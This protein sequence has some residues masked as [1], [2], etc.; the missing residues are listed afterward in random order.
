MKLSHG[1]LFNTKWTLSLL[2]FFV[3]AGGIFL[4][5]TDLSAPLLDFHPTRQLFGAIKARGIYY[6]TLPDVPAWQKDLAV[7]LYVVEA[8][9]E[10]PLME[11]LTAWLYT[12]SGVQ[13]AIPRAI[14]A[15]FWM[16]GGIFLFLLSRD[17]S[18][19]ALAATAALA[20]YLLVPYS[21]SASRAFQPDPLMV[22]FI[23][24]F[25]W[26]LENWARKLSW[27]WAVLSGLAGG[28]A[29]FIKF[30]ALLFIVVPAFGAILAWPGL[31]NALRNRQTWVIALL[32]ALLPGAYLV[33]GTLLNG[34]LNQ[35]FAGRMYPDLWLSLYFYLRWFLKLNNVVNILWLTLAFLGWLVFS[36]GSLR[37]FLGSLWV[38]YFIFGMTVTHH[39]SSHDYYSLPV[40]P[41]VAVCLAQLAAQVVPAV[42]NYQWPAQA[43]ER[44][45]FPRSLQV[46]TLVLLLASVLLLTFD[47]YSSQRAD[48]Y[49]PQAAFWA[50]VGDALNHQS[51]VL[52]L[53]TDYGYPLAY[54][55]WQKSSLWPAS[56]DIKAFDK[57][58]AELTANKSYFLI[59]DF[60]EYDRQPALQA[61][62]NTNYPILAYGNGFIVFDLVHP[63]K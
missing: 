22:M 56:A 25:W 2:L 43:S 24:I 34:F 26:S 50:Q 11:N 6:K 12:F 63:K 44:T 14:S 17:L 18:K 30:T 21:V 40:I 55:G 16:L 52:A 4:R 5:Y 9:I 29:I 46:V 60:A 33:Y 59:T 20:F 37:I 35:Q 27:K 49:R 15:S 36:R 42:I 19:S 58:F 62:L 39:I 10:P 61:R 8:T 31:K 57:T 38:S 1:N 45:P 53:T 32:G 28:L 13:T 7:R 47:Q 41:I 48:D 3:L 54:Y 23:I 51:G